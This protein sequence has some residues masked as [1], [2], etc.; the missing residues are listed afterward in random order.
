MPTVLAI[1]AEGFE[2]IEAIT[3]IDLLRRA[4]AEVTTAALADGIH[5]T[6]R[7]GFTLHADTTLTAL[8][9]PPSPT[10]PFVAAEIPPTFDCLLLPGGPGVKY[11]RADPRVHALVLRHHA[12][13]KWL[14]AICAA[15]TV[16][17]DA[18]LL[19]GRRYTA[20]FSVASEL[21]HIFDTEVTVADGPILTSR[22]AGTALQFG[23]LL[24][25]KLFTPEKS[26]EVA[27]S[28]CV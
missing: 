18:G 13:G 12:A 4:G 2:E 25:E 3:P 24:V 17:N 20:H 28:I 5:V 23:L 8:E 6:G 14:A 22:G 11:L 9:P 7:N 26:Q 15:P 10:G 1:L 27:R 19:N 21:P 16:L